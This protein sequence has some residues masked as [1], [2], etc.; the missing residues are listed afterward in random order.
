MATGRSRR[1]GL[2]LPKAQRDEVERMRKELSRL[3]TD[4]ESNITRAQKAV[5]FTGAELQG[6]PTTFL[7]QIKTADD[8]YTVMAN[9]TWQFNTVEENAKNEATRKQLYLVRETL[10]KDENVS[11]LNQMLT[12]RNKIAL[13]LGYKSWD[14]YQT[15]VKM[16]KTGMN[17]EKYINDLIAG[18]QPKFDSEVAE[19]Q[20][21]KA[22]DT[23]DP[24]AK[25]MVWD[26]R[27]YSNQL[28]KQ[29]Y[30]VDKE[31]LR[32]R[33]I[34]WRRVGDSPCSVRSGH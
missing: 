10:A 26:W 15:E 5:K 25:I 17:A 3:A 7:E 19:L 31:A 23:N 27:Y 16:A 14:D 1:A 29:K 12:L 34:R 9:V 13:R 32:H 11:V 28:N 6:V 21:L 22:A 2:D 30:A 24:N 20:K 33:D 4:Y 8:E 18:I